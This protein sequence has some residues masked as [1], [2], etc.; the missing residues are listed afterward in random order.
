ML[1]SLLSACG[2]VLPV[3]LPLCFQM[4]ELIEMD[5]L[6][7]WVYSDGVVGEIANPGVMQ[8]DLSHR[9]SVRKLV[10]AQLEYEQSGEKKHGYANI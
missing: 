2:S 9:G 1:N 3:G 6:S 4:C 8:R 5:G 10:L 7:P